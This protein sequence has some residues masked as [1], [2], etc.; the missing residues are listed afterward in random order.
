MPLRF[1]S[2]SSRIKRVAVFVALV[3][4]VAASFIAFDRGALAGFGMLLNTSGGR[5][6][7]LSSTVRNSKTCTPEEGAPGD[8]TSQI[9]DVAATAWVLGLMVGTHAF[10]S[11]W[12][13]ST[14]SSEAQQH[15]RALANERSARTARNIEKLAAQLQVP[16]PRRFTGQELADANTAFMSA[17]E[18]DADRT[19]RRIARRYSEMACHLYKLGA[20]WGYASE[21][22]NAL[23]SERSAFGPEI[24]YHARK[25]GVPDDL[26]EPAL[27]PR[28]ASASS[29][30]LAAETL[31]LT[32]AITSHLMKVRRA[33]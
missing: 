5:A 11:R 19:A 25:A 31:Q 1:A 2:L 20:Y 16:Q 8:G 14:A 3:W 22:S 33:P 18:A 27:A 6:L 12:E 4:T 29:E 17:V 10:T 15:W 28:H 32:Q 30:E 7:A 24:E 21:V 23:P 13:S 9:S 26:W